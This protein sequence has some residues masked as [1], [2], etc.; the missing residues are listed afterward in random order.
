MWLLISPFLV[1]RLC[2]VSWMFRFLPAES[3]SAV[4]QSSQPIT[5]RLNW[6][7]TNNITRSS[8]N[9]DNDQRLITYTDDSQFTWLWWWLPLRLSKHQS[10]SPQTVLLRTTLTFTELWY[11]S[12]V[13]TIYSF[14]Y[15][16]FTLPTK[17]PKNTK[18]KIIVNVWHDSKPWWF[19][20]NFA[21]QWPNVFQVVRHWLIVFLHQCSVWTRLDHYDLVFIN[22]NVTLGFSKTVLLKYIEL[23]QDCP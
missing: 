9:Q 6:Q 14:T 11:D 15:I 20:S 4:L 19:S 13:Q 10:M 23:M 1:A 2:A 12:W 5:S 3:L 16:P 22:I 18:R 8:T 21:R 7:T 17:C